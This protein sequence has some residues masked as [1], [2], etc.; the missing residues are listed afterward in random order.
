LHDKLGRREVGIYRQHGKLDGRWM[1]CVIV[2]RLL[3]AEN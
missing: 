2:E 1:G 3:A